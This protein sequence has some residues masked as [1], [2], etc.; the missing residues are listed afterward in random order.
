VS[1]QVDDIIDVDNAVTVRIT[2]RHGIRNRCRPVLEDV[3]NQID[4]IIDIPV[5][6]EIG[7]PNQEIALARI[8]IPVEVVPT[9]SQTITVR[10]GDIFFT[11]K[12][13]V[14]HPSEAATGLLAVGC[15]RKAQSHYTNRDENRALHAFLPS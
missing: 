5:E 8:G 11:A 13:A 4:D 14:V 2:R 6:T 9:M 3:V 10:L 7:V 1:Y 15:L 12:L